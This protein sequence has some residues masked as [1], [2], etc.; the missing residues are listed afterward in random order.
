MSGHSEEQSISHKGL[1]FVFDTFGESKAEPML[2]V[3]G[4]GN[5]MIDWR[6]DF[7]AQLAGRG[8]WVIRFDHRDAGRSGRIAGAKRLGLWALGSAYL[9]GTPIRA[10]YTLL[11]MAEDG[12]A[13][14]DALGVGS[15]HVVGGSLGGMIAQVLAVHHPKRVRSMTSLLC[16]VLDKPFPLP[17]MRAL[18]LFLPTPRDEAAQVGR[19]LQVARAMRGPRFPLDEGEIIEHAQ[20]RMARSPE[21]PGTQRQ[22]AALLATPSWL[23]GLRQLRIPTLIIHGECDPVLPLAHGIRASR[24]I[25]GAKLHVVPGL[26]H[27][28]P[29]PVWGEVIDVIAA[30]A[31]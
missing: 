24:L 29:R 15:A 19:A 25:P 1:D 31:R 20:L 8:Y 18:V 12:L 21:P 23:D 4:L 17:Y 2:L 16:A 9:F 22:M 14:L 28:L 26:G 3:S 27:E 6:D 7:C 13:V 5:Q 30:H 10:A 11:D